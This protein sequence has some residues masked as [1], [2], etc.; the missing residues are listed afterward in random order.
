MIVDF[1]R[2]EIQTVKEDV[3]EIKEELKEIKTDVHKLLQF[4]WQI[5]GGAML[6]AGLVTIVVEI[7]L[8]ILKP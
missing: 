2:A 5:V 3:T 1:L 4:K 8:V 6:G 7:L